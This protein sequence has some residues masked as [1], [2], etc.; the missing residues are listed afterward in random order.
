MFTPDAPL[1]IKPTLNPDTLRWML[2]FALRCNHRDYEASARAK[3]TLLADSRQRIQQWVTRYQLDCEF[4]ETGEDYVF[5][6]RRD[7]DRELGDVP[8]LRELGVD[9]EVV[10]RGAIMGPATT[11]SSLVWLA[12]CVF[13]VM[14]LCAPTVTLRNLRG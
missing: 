7:M 8:M 11:P 5:R 10:G 2:G 6:T 4:A 1:Y 14:P 13:V 9:V 3:Y 12:H